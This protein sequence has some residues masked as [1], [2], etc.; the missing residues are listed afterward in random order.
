MSRLGASALRV[1]LSGKICLA[2]LAPPKEL[3]E[4]VTE[5]FKLDLRETA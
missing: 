4:K 5:D 1:W 2:F 3:R